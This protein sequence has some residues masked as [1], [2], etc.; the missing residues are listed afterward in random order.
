V[1]A[2]LQTAN[3]TE[4]FVLW[5]EIVPEQY[6]I[7]SEVDSPEGHKP[8]DV[9]ELVDALRPLYHVTPYVR[10]QRNA[11]G[12]FRTTKFLSRS[13][14]DGRLASDIGQHEVERDVF[15]VEMFIYPGLDVA[16]H[17]IGVQVVVVLQQQ[18]HIIGVQV[19]VVLLQQ[20]QHIISVMYR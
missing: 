9:R 5:G 15:T 16:R 2:T 18:Q 19:V 14:L 17:C 1:G 10:R 7:C 8:I 20:Q 3:I 4:Q 12:T 11:I 6:G 13:D